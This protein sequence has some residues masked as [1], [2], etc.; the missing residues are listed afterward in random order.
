MEWR[1]LDFKEYWAPPVRIF[2]IQ[3]DS[4]KNEE[5]R[6]RA[7]TTI[8]EIKNRIGSGKIVPVRQLGGC[9]VLRQV[10]QCLLSGLCHFSSFRILGLSSLRQV[11]IHFL[12]QR[13][14]EP[15]RDEGTDSPRPTSRRCGSPCGFVGYSEAGV[16]WGSIWCWLLLDLHVNWKSPKAKWKT[17]GGACPL[18]RRK[19]DLGTLAFRWGRWPSYNRSVRQYPWATRACR[20]ETIQVQTGTRR[21]TVMLVECHSIVNM[22]Q[23]DVFDMCNTDSVANLEH[24]AK[25][26]PPHSYCYLLVDNIPY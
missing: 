12:W 4:T 23:L 13:A 21:L 17:L 18:D 14:C 3:S 5:T 25:A 2:Q 26:R 10:P 19:R 7:G 22:S 6:K 11:W 20:L 1:A 15:C 16:C 24:G 8:K 9:I